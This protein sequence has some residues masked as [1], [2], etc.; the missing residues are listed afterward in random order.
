MLLSEFI[1]RTGVMP[2][3]EEYARIEAEYYEFNGD[4]DAFCRAWKRANPAAV[5]KAKE[6][7][8]RNAELAKVFTIFCRLGRWKGAHGEFSTRAYGVLRQT[9]ERLLD[10][11]GF[12]LKPYRN[13]KWYYVG[14]LRLDLQRF[15]ENSTERV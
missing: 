9:E 11:I 12:N 1:D 10:K 8:V 5:K 2:S 15:F 6:R 4:K 3:A 13:D 14:D 7:K